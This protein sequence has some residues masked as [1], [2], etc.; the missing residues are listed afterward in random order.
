V[1]DQAATQLRS[2]GA[3]RADLVDFAQYVDERLD[4]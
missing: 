3:M 1:D 4:E 2:V